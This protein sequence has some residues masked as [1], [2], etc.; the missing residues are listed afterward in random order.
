MSEVKAG[1]IWE[2]AELRLDPQ[3]VADFPAAAGKALAILRAAPGC[4][5][6]IL[7][8]G[9]EDPT[10]PRF[11]IQW[12]DVATHQAF[13]DSPT[14]AEYRAPIASSFAQP[15]VFQHYQVEAV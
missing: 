13:R 6:A 7:M 4:G 10:S 12:R 14:F 5:G 15:P 1:E 2:I 11:L 8:S 3:A 9:V